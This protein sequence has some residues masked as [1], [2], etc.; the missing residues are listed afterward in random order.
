MRKA[1]S[2]NPSAI[3]WAAFALILSVWMH[4][5]VYAETKNESKE[6]GTENPS[7]YWYE[8]TVVRHAWMSLDE[9]AVFKIK[10]TDSKKAERSAGEVFQSGSVSYRAN[11]SLMVVTLPASMEQGPLIEKI[12]TLRTYDSIRQASPIFYIGEKKTPTA[13]YILTGQIIVRFPDGC[14]KSTVAEVEKTFDLKR[15]KTFDF[16]SNAVLYECADPMASITTANALHVSGQVDYAY[17]NWL[18]TRSKRAVPDDP[19]YSDQWHLDNTGQEGGVIGADVNVESVWDTYQGSQNEVIAI[20]DDGLEIGHEDLSSNVVS[21]QSYDYV[22]EDSDPTDG[23]HGTSCAGVAAGRGF[24]QTGI[25]GAAPNAGLI[26]HRLLGAETDANEADALF[27]NND[28]IDIYSNSWGPADGGQVLEG[29]GPLTDSAFENGVLNGRGGLGSIFVWAGGNGYDSD[30]SNYD[31]YAN[32]RYTIAVAAST[33]LGTQADYSE[34]G[35][36]ILIN[37]PSSGG[38]IDI[39]TTDRTGDEG[40]NPDDSYE[41]YIDT[42]YTKTFGGTSSSAPLAAGVIAL[43][44][45]ANPNLSWR[46]VQQIL[47][48]SAQKNDPNDEDWATNGAGYSVNHKHGFGRIDA[49]AA[50]N[51]ALQWTPVAEEVST[52]SSSS[53]NLSIPDDDSAGVSDTIAVSSDISVEYVEVYFSAADHPYWGDLGIVL[54]SPAGTESVLSETHSSGRSYTY[55]DWRFGSVRHFGE[56]SLGN[57]TLKV[58]D[59][60][61]VDTGTFQS[62]TLKIFGTGTV[63]P[64]PEEPDQTEPQNPDSS[65]SD[66]DGDGGGGGG[67]CFILTGA[68]R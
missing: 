40:Y 45:E 66:S 8:R 23:D 57:W 30:D 19:L 58:V 22:D 54:V 55:D 42:N 68:S 41:D 25:S 39:V 3:I 5:G 11:S 38:S 44:L 10:E 60:A 32:S 29:P 4:A 49:Q 9:V 34:K 36:N 1:S 17:P 13:R 56:S 7:I 15:L 50:V 47:I 28:L 67:G 26:G 16:S 2:I 33:N 65:S 61:S 63:E 51:E 35:A 27:R 20:V 43:I 53:P 18:R 46:D 59:G 37:A 31:G 48:E 14:L 21:G 64:T 6:S 52:E 24:N 62:W 12:D